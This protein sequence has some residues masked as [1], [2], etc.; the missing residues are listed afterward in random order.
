MKRGSA[1]ELRLCAEYGA[2][3]GEESVLQTQGGRVRSLA[4]L[5]ILREVPLLFQ[6]C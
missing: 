5:S 3:Q 4:F 6:T 1:S 2:S